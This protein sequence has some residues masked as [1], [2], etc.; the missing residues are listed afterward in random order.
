MSAHL[1]FPLLYAETIELLTSARARAGGDQTLIIASEDRRFL[2]SFLRALIEQ[3]STE[4]SKSPLLC[5]KFRFLADNLHSPPPPPPTLA[6]AKEA[7][8]QL[9]GPSAEVVH[10]FLASIIVET[11]ND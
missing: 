2:S 9:A 8:R 11:I 1:E 7:A 6:E 5:N 10:A 3:T 4:L